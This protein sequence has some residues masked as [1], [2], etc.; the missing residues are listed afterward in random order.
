MLKTASIDEA[1][2]AA[3]RAFVCSVGLLSVM[4]RPPYNRCANQSN[5][6]IA[7]LQPPVDSSTAQYVRLAPRDHFVGRYEQLIQ[8]QCPMPG[9]T[10]PLKISG[11][12]GPSTLRMPTSPR[13]MRDRAWS[14]K[15]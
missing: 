2:T 15:V 1:T 9:M 12:G 4:A 10:W 7:H 5:E 3:R 14:T 13:S 11:L 6:R 8:V